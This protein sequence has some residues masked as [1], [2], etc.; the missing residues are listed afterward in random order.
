MA[1]KALN[2]EALPIRKNVYIWKGDFVEFS[3]DFAQ[4]GV[5]YDLTGYTGKADIVRDDIKI[6]EFDVT[7]NA[8]LGEAVITL[9]SSDSALLATG[10]YDW[11]FQLVQSATGRVRTYM[12][13]K[14]FVRGEITV[15]I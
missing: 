4:G 14:V 9:E 5:A 3:V 8:E 11:D 7:I 6:A 10:I 2:K 1:S 15:G 13:G 12:F